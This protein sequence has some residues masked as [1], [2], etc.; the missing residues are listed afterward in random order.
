[1]RKFLSS[2]LLALA[3][4][5]FGLGSPAM[6]ASAAN[7]AGVFSA[8]C[9]ACHSGGLNV[10]N[11]EKTLQKGVLE[12]N[13]MLSAEAIMTQ[14]TNGKNAMPAFGGTLTADQIADA[15]AYVLEQAEKGW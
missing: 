15:A 1:M 7:G 13:G 8:N 9:A 14:A 5:T 6:A 10:I 11:P 3:V 12:K 2:M 4:L